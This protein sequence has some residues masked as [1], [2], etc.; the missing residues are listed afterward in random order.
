MKLPP[1]I[2]IKTSKKGRGLFASRP[3]K[4]G[5]LI[6][7]F[8]GRIDTNVNTNSKSLQIWTDKFLESIV[9]DVDNSPL[10]P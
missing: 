3:L 10:T 4:K 8:K 1:S 6:F 2:E 5:E 9:K 7:H